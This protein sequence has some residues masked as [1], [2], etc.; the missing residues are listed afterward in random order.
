MSYVSA[1][2]PRL[3]GK[4]RTSGANKGSVGMSAASRVI[5]V[6]EDG[7]AEREAMARV[8][9][10]EHY[11]V[12]TAENPQQAL[13]Y[14]DQPVDLIISDLRMGKSSGLDL[15]RTWESRR[16]GTP[17]IMVTAYGDVESAVAA[18]KMGAVDYLTKPV[19]PPALLALIQR[20]LPRRPAGGETAA[21]LD[22]RSGFEKIIGDSPAMLRVF[23]Q[24]RRAAQTES[25]I[26]ILGE[27][28]TGKELI[29]E[30]IHANSPRHGG[31]FVLVNMAAIP[32]TL[33]E[34]ELF[35]HVRG[36]FTGASADR[37]GRFEAAQGGTI[38]IDEI[39]DFPAASQAKLLRVLENRTAARIGSNQDKPVNVR[40]V[41]ATSRSLEQ[42]VAEG[43]FRED[44][45]YRLKVV[46]LRLP[47]LRTRRDDIPRLVDYFLKELC[48]A[49]PG[50]ELTVDAELLRYLVGA[51][52]PGNVR[53]LRNCLESMVVMAHTSRLTLADLPTGV[54]GG[55]GPDAFF[56]AEGQ[57]EQR[58][59]DLQREVILR[60]L[61]QFEGNRTH[62]AEAL[63]ISV[64]T[65]QRRLKEW[66]F[67]DEPLG[68]DFRS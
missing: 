28:G 46:V 11:E 15:L 25:T 59:E 35:G 66:G 6:V 40:V 42:M 38:F 37:A 56:P 3:G 1:T 65:L 22:A 21:E 33:V 39:G 26:L 45:Y 36:A 41:A 60:T 20:C 29:A 67:R 13:N 19:N 12:L 23:D 2:V 50:A 4:D 10:L 48:R 24:T 63:G 51:D 14:L 43:R 68:P 49:K 8:L 34:S 31:P 54:T 32:E 47:P 16:P 30:A 62:A 58:L 7:P 57:K 9:R 44:L 52:W 61:R 64:R 18:M 53:Q 5:L 55:T 27:S 17:L